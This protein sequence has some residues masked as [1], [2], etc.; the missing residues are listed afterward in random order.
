MPNIMSLED[1]KTWPAAVLKFLD[2]KHDL[3]LNFELENNNRVS[4]PEYDQ[5]LKRLR[6]VLSTD[7]ELL[8]YHCTRLIDSEIQ[9]IDANGLPLPNK[10]LLH[11][12]IDS[13]KQEGLIDPQCSEHLKY[14][15]QA[16]EPYREGRIWFCFYPP[17][18][19]GQDGIE[20]LFRSWGGE[21]L[22]NSHEKDPVYGPILKRIGTPCIIEAY[23]PII[24][25][26]RYDGLEDKVVRRYLVNRGL[27]TVEELDH[28]SRA[29]QPIPSKNI[30]RIIKFPDSDFIKLTQCDTREPPLT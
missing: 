27:K 21:V 14:K 13:I 7:Y 28:E 26:P 11:K 10:E 8:G 2:N 15:N 18:R 19:A 17:Y 12:R 5:V 20:R 9:D 29:E 23:V 4:R 1:E 30:S 6:D 24:S 22:Y 16:D 3:F 25:L